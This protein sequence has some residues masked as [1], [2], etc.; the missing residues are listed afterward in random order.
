MGIVVE[1][2]AQFQKEM[3]SAIAFLFYSRNHGAT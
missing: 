2:M 3:Q 1:E